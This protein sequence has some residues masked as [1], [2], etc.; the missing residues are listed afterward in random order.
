MAPFYWAIVRWAQNPFYA[1]DV[2]DAD[3]DDDTDA[4]A[5][6]DA[7]ADTWHAGR[8]QIHF[9]AASQTGPVLFSGHSMSLCNFSLFWAHS[10]FQYISGHISTP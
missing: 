1:G 9:E 5:D 10:S 2:A 8:P 6:S 7:D 3:T 4:D